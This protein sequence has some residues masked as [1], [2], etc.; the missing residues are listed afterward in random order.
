MKRFFPFIALL[1]MALLAFSVV[2][3]S[4]AVY[5]PPMTPSV[6]IPAYVTTNQN[7][8][9]YVNE[10]NGFSNYTVT[11]YLAGENLSGA[12]P[13]FSYHN[14]QASNPDF[15]VSLRAPSTA[16]VLYINIISGANYGSKYVT[17]QKSFTVHVI[18][19]I[20]FYAVVSN[21]GTSAIHNLTVDFSVDNQFV[22][23]TVAT[24]IPAGGSVTVNFT[25]VNPY[26]TNGEHT[27]TVSVNNKAV[28]VDG[29][30]AVYTTHFYYGKPPNYNWIYYVAAIVI[31]FMIFLA[32]TAGRR[33]ATPNRP[34]W[35]K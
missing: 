13:S 23:S 21:T 16:Q 35:R 14:F 7:F 33:S 27:L 19:P 24:F 15:K 1:I 29:S 32:L 2:G 9:V 20:Y 25:Y 12:S 22:G 30:A 3:A 17:E 18:E 26:L 28:S 6:T 34:K 4:H 10:T 31:A 8:T 11:L 5:V